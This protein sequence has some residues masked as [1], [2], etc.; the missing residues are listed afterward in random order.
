MKKNWKNWIFAAIIA[1]AAITV[2]FIGC[3]NDET[4]KTFTVTFD[5][6]GGT[7]VASQTVNEGSKATKPTDPVK[8]N[9]VGGLYLGTPPDYTLIGWFNGSTQWDFNSPVTSNMTLKAHW[10]TPVHI[11]L[12]GTEGENILAQTFS[13]IRENV[14]TENHTLLLNADIELSTAL[15]SE[16]INYDLTI[17][18]IGEERTL[19]RRGT[20]FTVGTSMA[21]NYPYDPPYY[22]SNLTLGKN[23][24]LYNSRM[25]V[26]DF[27]VRLNQG[28]F[29]M[30][31]GSKIIGN[32]M[33]SG[34]YNN[35]YTFTMNGGII[36]GSIFS[37][38][39]LS[40]NE[41]FTISGNAVINALDLSYRNHFFG[42]TI[43]SE[44]TGSIG[45]LNLSKT[46]GPIPDVETLL[47]E[48]T[49]KEII[50]GT[51]DYIL[52]EIDITKITLGDFWTSAFGLIPISD[53]HKL[54]LDT[55]NNVIKLVAK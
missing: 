8:E 37:D 45:K 24:T 43:S 9:D 16:N 5:S 30:L 52:T 36:T 7:S 3:G 50:K 14:I 21:S 42:V 28:S 10:T 15:G 25:N 33:C 26:A 29:T 19:T 41:T 39:N 4:T 51:S 55:V 12:T 20:L 6:D 34:G 47:N 1:A 2:G 13:Y 48:W 49:G 46:I 38:H 44:W 17:I 18:G 23:I 53:S 31:E 35:P 22:T 27:I 32:I 40:Q 54:E 11:D